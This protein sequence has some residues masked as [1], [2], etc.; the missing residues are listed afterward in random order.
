MSC[1]IAY[2]PTHAMFKTVSRSPAV[3]V[4]ASS[5][6]AFLI[7]PKVSRPLARNAPYALRSSIRFASSSNEN[8]F[9]DPDM[10]KIQD[11]VSKAQLNPV[12]RELL[13]DFQ[14][15][16]K[17]KGFNPDEQPSMTQIMRLFAD[18]EVRKLLL[19]LKDAFDEAGIKI[20]PDEIGLFMKL[21]KKE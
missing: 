15:I 17:E 20:S 10:M 14:E 13:Q 21:F 18:K 7:A 3:R 19:K 4:I 9:P 5:S 12:I 16:I 6:R 2:I 1:V 8:D 11:V